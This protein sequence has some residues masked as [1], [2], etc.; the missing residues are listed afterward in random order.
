MSRLALVGPIHPLRGGIAQHTAGIVATAR[1]RGHD[2]RVLSY[3]RQYPD[4][5]FP[6][7]TQWADGPGPPE[8]A[9]ETS[10]PL[11]SLAP[12]T[13]WRT[14][15]EVLGFS[16]DVVALQ[17]W[18]PF[19]APALATIA[20][21]ARR[22]AR[23]AWLVHNA[24]PHEGGAAW[25][26][27][28]RLGYAPDDT[29]L[30]HAAAEEAALRELGVRGTIAHVPMPAPETVARV[31][32]DEARGRIDCGDAEIVFLF[33]GHV[34]AYKGVDL[35]LEALSRLPEEG[36]RW[37]AL[38]VGEWYIER[39][40]ADERLRGSLGERV[41]IVDRF[42][43]DAYTADCFAAADVVVLPYRSGTQS[44]VVPLAYAH[45]RPVVTTRVGGLPEIVG[46]PETGLLVPPGDVDALVDALG[47]VRRGHRF[48]I[49]AIDDA[50]RRA[51]FVPLVDA[52]TSIV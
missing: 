24:R 12:W 3:R 51:S 43:S 39:G 7:R 25:G 34:R 16:P 42:V 40:P 19:F 38:V 18:H 33:Y 29:C 15:G 49:E 48:S 5:L 4:F 31:P 45:G 1:A 32:R 17:Q 36:P 26:R 35:L 6:G 21:R 44:A 50:R 10:A 8:A 52:L 11:D 46:D 28:L 30:V 14:A 41:R 37:R 23:V 13:W 9:Q 27:L 2:V 20:A 22:R 47:R